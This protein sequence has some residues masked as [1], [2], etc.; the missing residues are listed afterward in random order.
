M[1]TDCTFQTENGRFNC[2]VGAIIMNGTKLL[3]AHN[4]SCDQYYTV[5]GRVKLHETSEE[6]VIR[7]VY[8]ETGVKAEID[9][10]GFIQE[11]F[12]KIDGAPYHELAFF[13]YIKPFDYS[14]INFDSI[15]CDGD[16]E[17]LCW[18]DLTALPDAEFYPEFFKTE[19]LAPSNA[20]KHFIT[21]EY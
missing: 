6:A 18:V 17:E 3:M 5:G 13:Y 12:Y 21:R 14:L 20:I 19:L 9:R 2:R 15:K 10:L 8:E 1:P 16:A 7:E 11:N 4:R